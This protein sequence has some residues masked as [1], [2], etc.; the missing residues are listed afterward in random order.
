M[1]YGIWSQLGYV[2]VG[3]W[4]DCGVGRTDFFDGERGG[5]APYLPV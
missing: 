2:G 1:V 5:W 4:G 3:G